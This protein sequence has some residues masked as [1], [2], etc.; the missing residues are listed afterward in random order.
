MAVTEGAQ[1]QAGKETT[2]GTAVTPTVKIMGADVGS[3][4][5]SSK[6]ESPVH[7]WINGSLG[8]GAVGTLNSVM[9][10]LS[11]SGT[12]LYEDIAYF[13]DGIFSEATPSGAGPYTRAY[14]GATTASTTPRIFTIVYGQGSD[15]YKVAGC[16]LNELTIKGTWNGPLTYD[17]SFIGQQQT[18]GTLAALS[19]RAVNVVMGNHVALSIDALGGTIGTTAVATTAFDFEW[20]INANRA[21]K[22]YFGS[23][24]AQ[25]WEGNTYESSLKLS[26]EMNATSRA[27]LATIF[28]ATPAVYQRLVRISADDTANRRLRIDGGWHLSEDP[29]L[30]DDRDGVLTADFNFE[31]IQDN[32]AFANWVSVSSINGVSALP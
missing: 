12:V 26:M 16:I 1:L 20:K 15:T 28:G 18:A 19:D 21:A 5:F 32:G 25:G 24:L 9:G 23:V 31:A 4:K 17:V 10:E 14:T 11:W 22:G 30:F 6:R 3:V 2:W 27:Y 29:E 13:L 8:P 7:K